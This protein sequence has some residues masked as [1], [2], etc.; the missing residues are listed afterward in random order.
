MNRK[1]G[2]MLALLAYMCWGH[3]P[4]FWSFLSHVHPLAVVAHR[5]LWSAVF[6]FALLTFMRAWRRVL[7]LFVAPKTVWM[8]AFSGAMLAGNWLIY[9]W[10]V[11]SGQVI[12]ASLGYFIT[13]LMSV[14]LGAIF[15]KERLKPYQKIAVVLACLGVVLMALMAKLTPWTGLAIAASF[16]A[17][18]LLRKLQPVASLEGL[19]L[20]TTLMLLPA[21]L[22]LSF[23]VDAGQVWDFAAA[24]P[25]FLLATGVVTTVPLLAFAQAARDLDLATL[26]VLQYVSPMI[27]FLLGAFY[28]DEA[29]GARWLG[30]GVIWLALLIFSL[31]SV[32][33][34]VRRR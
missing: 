24:T 25:W 2:V 30:F 22:L 17:Y 31:G 7:P 20:E 26:G 1:R 32:L 6:L 4:L 10:A 14:F 21:L 34:Y 5:V 33:P 18:G 11:G 9:V 28:F 27:Q 16:G 15:L 13:P 29:M 23:G 19:F 3:F 8:C 12:E